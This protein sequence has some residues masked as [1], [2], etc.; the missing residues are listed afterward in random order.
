MSADL[1]GIMLD[2]QIPRTNRFKEEANEE[3]TP[4]TTAYRVKSPIST[5]SLAMA[6]SLGDFMLK[7]NDE[8]PRDKQIVCNN[9]INPAHRSHAALQLT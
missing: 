7:T 1:V 8:L 4:L 3:T 5:V 2:T 9:M 6:R